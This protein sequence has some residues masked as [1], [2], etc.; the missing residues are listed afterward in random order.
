MAGK[1]Y[2]WYMSTA[3]SMNNSYYKDLIWQ[4][5]LNKPV[6][7]VFNGDYFIKHRFK[8]QPVS[9][10]G[11]EY[12]KKTFN[13]SG[14]GNFYYGAKESE[15]RIWSKEKVNNI[16][17]SEAIKHVHILHLS[18]RTKRFNTSLDPNIL[19]LLN[20]LCNKLQIPVLYYYDLHDFL[21]FK[22]GQKE[23]QQDDN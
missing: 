7:I 19:K 18:R 16:K 13:K 23:M 11:A 14:P 12:D 22:D 17:P 20:E 5:S 6:N 9:Y 10:Y 2:D 4:G 8:I 15:E 21:Y 3:R 1:E